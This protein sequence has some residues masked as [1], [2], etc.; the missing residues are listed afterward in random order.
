VQ[1][2]SHDFEASFF[3]TARN[4]DSVDKWLYGDLQSVIVSEFGTGE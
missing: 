4:T 1:G 2:G 3:L